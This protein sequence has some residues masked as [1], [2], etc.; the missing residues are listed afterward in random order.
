[1][2]YDFRIRLKLRS[3]ASP[4]VLFLQAFSVRDFRVSCLAVQAS[5]HEVCVISSQITSS[6]FRCQAE[7]DKCIQAAHHGHHARPKIGTT[8]SN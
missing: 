7:L 5:E 8:T 1:M 6:G 4:C 2:V 3:S